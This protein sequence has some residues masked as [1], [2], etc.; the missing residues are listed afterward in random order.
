MGR[1]L[2][3]I[4]AGEA[5]IPIVRKAKE[6]G[7]ISV[8]F[9]EADSIAKNEADIFIEKNI[10]DISGM[11]E[12]CQ[13]N[14]VNGIIAS[15]EITTESA[16]ILAY[17]MGLPGN[18]CIEGYCV[19]NKYIMR[20]KIQLCDGV[21]QPDFFLYSN[22]EIR[23]FPIMIKA[24]D[25]CGK[26]GISLVKNKDEC[27]KAI[28]IA[29][30]ISSDG[31]VLIEEYISNGEEYSVECLASGKHKYII[32]ITEKITS[33]PPYFTEIAHHHGA[34]LNNGQSF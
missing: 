4:G 34:R 24:V 28:N 1:I 5:A 2:A 23:R 22:E 20:K 21:K 3:I 9:G 6:M 12:E 7:I 33:G 32:Q 16:A 26:K 17:R 15:S 11:E 18:K 25:S 19:R 14:K 31:S 8:A 29:K 27:G 10:F 30:S 13:K